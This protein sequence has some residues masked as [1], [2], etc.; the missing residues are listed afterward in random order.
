MGD[1]GLN[2]EAISIWKEYYQL[3]GNDKMRDILSIVEIVYKKNLWVGADYGKR[4]L[5]HGI[6][7]GLIA[8]QALIFF[9]EL[10]LGF[11]KYKWLDSVSDKGFMSKQENQNDISC[12]R[13]SKNRYESIQKD[14][15]NDSHRINIRGRF[16][17]DEWFK[18]V[19]WATSSAAIH[20]IIQLEEYRTECG[21]HLIDKT[22]YFKIALDDDPL[23]FLGLLVDKLQEWDRYK[24]KP[25]GESAF[26]GKEL[27]Q[28][29]GVKL[30]F[31]RLDVDHF[32]AVILNNELWQYTEVEADHIHA[33][34]IYLT[35][36]KVRAIELKEGIEQCLEDDWNKIVRILPDLD[37]A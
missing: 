21:K 26:S 15:I 35:Y 25:R 8:L 2:R 29:T 6:C 4:S 10:Y 7:S 30:N 9:R 13:V 31:S 37:G 32:K 14:V 17:A 18:K 27:L 34:I 20:S 12:N 19:C 5:D 33:E 23:A 16:K 3:Y 22:P 36:P 1:Y 11:K 24:V 28:S